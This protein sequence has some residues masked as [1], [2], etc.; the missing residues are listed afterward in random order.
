MEE[1]GT[2]DLQL[3]VRGV[4]GHLKKLDPAGLTELCWEWF[5]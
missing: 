3:A 4:S 1:E 2:V 5:S